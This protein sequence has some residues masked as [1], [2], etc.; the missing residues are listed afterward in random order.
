MLY[1]SAKMLN[2]HITVFDQKMIHRSVFTPAHLC[3]NP[4]F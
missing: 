3:D 1:N 2:T 4:T